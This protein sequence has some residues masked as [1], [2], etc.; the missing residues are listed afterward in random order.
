MTIYKNRVL[1]F[2]KPCVLPLLAGF[3]PILYLFSANI[4]QGTLN[5]LVLPLSVA[6]AVV[7][8]LTFL[9][10][11]LFK[12]ALQGTLAAAALIIFSFSYGHLLR[13]FE[14]TRIGSFLLSNY[15]IFLL[16]ILLLRTLRTIWKHPEGIKKLIPI[17]T[18]AAA[19]L[20]IFQLG[21]IALNYKGG[22][23]GEKIALPAQS[24][25]PATP[26]DA[27]SVSAKH[28]DIYY[29]ILDNYQRKDSLVN[30]LNFDNSEF[31]NEM[32][33]RG[34]YVASQTSANYVMTF[35]SLSSSLNMQYHDHEFFQSQ[36]WNNDRAIPNEMIQNNQVVAV[37]RQY[38]Y[39]FVNISS[40]WGPTD[41]I[42][43]ADQNIRFSELNEFNLMILNTTILKPFLDYTS[44]ENKRMVIDYSFNALGNMPPSDQPRFIFAH[45]LTP[46]PPYVFNQDG[47]APSFLNQTYETYAPEYKDAF[48][49]QLVYTN[50]RVLQ[51]VDQILKNNPDNPPIIIIQADHGSSFGNHTGA[52]KG[53]PWVHTMEALATGKFD[54]YASDFLRERSN[55]LNL[56]YLPGDGKELLYPTITPVNTFR[57]ILDHYL[58]TQYGLLEDKT[59]FSSY[60]EVF[61][62]HEA[63]PDILRKVGDSQ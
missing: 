27:A 40:G 12:N 29:I 9:L 1:T 46:H 34:F 15:V 21:F 24:M 38:G 44:R 5:M 51:M 2:L 28:P 22:I 59:I 60:G 30:V 17:C 52:V 10:C 33:N 55:I 48:L 25:L 6:T 8:A 13:Y 3:F 49:N 23:F 37:L 47:S 54:H 63:P 45:M 58:G 7:L 62:F 36:Q 31:L 35:L 43:E 16:I 57:L 32:E 18:L 11:F 53:G 39:R 19:G 14:N 41:N 42:A 50:H 4:R 26:P 61:E 20:V 56:Y